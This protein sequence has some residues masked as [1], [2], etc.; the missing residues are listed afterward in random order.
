MSVQ[1]IYK[2]H[3]FTP[4]PSVRTFHPFP[5]L[6]PEVR[7]QIWTLTVLPPRIL[8]IETLCTKRSPVALS[9]PLFSVCREARVTALEAYN[10]Y[11]QWGHFEATFRAHDLPNFHNYGRDVKDRI[12]VE[13]PYNE[14]VTQYLAQ[15]LDFS[16]EFFQWHKQLFSPYLVDFD[17]DVFV[18][19]EKTPA[20]GDLDFLKSSVDGETLAQIKHVALLWWSKPRKGHDRRHGH[21]GNLDSLYYLG[22][23]R[24]FAGLKTVTFIMENTGTGELVTLEEVD[25]MEALGDQTRQFLQARPGVV[26]RRA[27]LVDV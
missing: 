14:F 11:T 23:L 10:S 13:S 15:K 22:T 12:S 6:P 26:F 19:D 21:R 3:L 1:Q 2:S 8:D 18:L 27:N 4:P 20:S 24:E 16:G 5:R 9:I 25:S 17:R 7:L